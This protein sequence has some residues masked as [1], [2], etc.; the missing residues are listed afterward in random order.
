MWDG[1][2]RR[3]FPR[4]EYPC[5]LTVR[6]KTPPPFSILTHTENISIGG[7]RVVID[8]EIEVATEVDVEIDLQDTLPNV[9]STGKISW[10][11]QFLVDRKDQTSRP[12][13]K[14]K[15]LKATVAWIKKIPAAQEG[16]PASYDTGIQFVTLKDED[17][18]RIADIVD[19]LLGK[20][21]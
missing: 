4:A 2:E 1:K 12:T 10:V 21:N 3:R 16:K 11:R 18:T 6:K 5:L 20:N 15:I 13:P 17:R 8:K 14:T 19:R 9:T 7:V